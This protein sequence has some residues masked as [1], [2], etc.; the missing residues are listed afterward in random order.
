MNIPLTQLQKE[1]IIG[2]IL[3]DSYLDCTKSGS[4]LQVKQSEKYKE[5]V[6]WLYKELANLCKS[7]PK[8]RKDNMQWYFNTR[9]IKELSDLRKIFYPN[10]KKIVPNNISDLL[11]SPRSLAIWYMDDGGLDYRPGDHY[12]FTITTN[13]FSIKENRLLVD[14]LKRNFKIEVNIQTPL[15][16]GK[17][18]PELYIGVV[19]RE[20]FLFLIR[21]YILNCF[22]RKLPPFIKI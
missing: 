5:Y 4:R 2:T 1:I 9:Y 11:V 21:P 12:N 3:G 20:R 22:S 14:V 18:Y 17:R 6:F 16:R 10:G 13:S 15:C 7:C 19:G 8:Q